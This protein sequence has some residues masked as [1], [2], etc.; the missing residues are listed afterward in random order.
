M[1]KA[2]FNVLSIQEFL[3]VKNDIKLVMRRGVEKGN[4]DIIKRKVEKEKMCLLLKTVD[5]SRLVN[6][7]QISHQKSIV[8]Y[9]SKSMELAKQAYKA[10]KKGD[11]ITFGRLLNYP[12]CCVDFYQYKIPQP[13][14]DEFSFVLHT[15]SNTNGKPSFYTNN[16]FNFQTR[17]PTKHKLNILNSFKDVLGERIRHFLISH[18]PCSFRCKESIR[19]GREIFKL[20]KKENKR[21]ARD[22]VSDLRKI[23]LVL[24]DFNWVSFDGKLNRNSISFRKAYPFLALHPEEK[25]IRGNKVIV[26]SDK[27]KILKDGNLLHE[28]RKPNKNFGVLDFS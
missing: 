28:I 15:F 21:F 5:T 23:F 8:A 19:I 26:N 24:D 16:I 4:I 18:I 10:E 3:A 11:Q 27:I 7:N 9:I 22:I 20:L 12:E 14:G 1:D 6:K 17:A 2:I 13:T 25:F